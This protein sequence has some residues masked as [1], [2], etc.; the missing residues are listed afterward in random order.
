MPRRRDDGRAGG[1][2]EP[3]ITRDALTAAALAVLARE[4]LDALTMRRVAAELD[5]QA[6]SL[7]WHVRNKDELLDLLADAVIADADFSAPDGPWREQVRILA[8]RYR[9][10]LRSH[11]DAARV[12]A[13]RFVI[14]PNSGRAME[15]SLAIFRSAGFSPANA[16]AALYLVSVVYVQGFALQEAVPMRAVEATGGTPSD[17]MDVVAAELAALPPA[18]FPSLVEST[19][20][21]VSLNLDDRFAWGLECVLDGLEIRLAQQLATEQPG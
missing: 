20:Y 9:D 16:A 13:G 10:H 19:G 11:R 4:G 21:L 17:A 5:V 18:Q 14:G 15:Q 6:A 8:H 7:Y 1:G 2:R 12:V 3:G